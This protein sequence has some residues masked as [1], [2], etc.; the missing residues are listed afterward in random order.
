MYKKAILIIAVG[1]AAGLFWFWAKPWV[2]SPGRF[3]QIG[4][5]LKPL[6]T[7]SALISLIGLAFLL[8]K[9]FY[10][11]ILVSVLAG[12]PFFFV[13]GLS[14]FYFGAFV[15]MVLLFMYAMRN[16]QAEAGERMK[17]NIR[18]IM[19]GGL[20]RIVTAIL[21]MIS[22][23]FFFSPTVQSSAKKKQLPPTFQQVIE[24]TVNTFL[25]G[26]I[27]NLPPQERQQAENQVITQVMTQFTEFLGPYFQYLPPILAFGLFLILQGLSFIFVWLAVAMA[28][29][30]FWVFK[31]AG[32][33]R[34]AVVQKEAEKLEF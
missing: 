30:I 2:E 33:V 24:R 8:F 29:L 21:I 34:L 18:V 11:K 23:A 28:M 32:M 22:F 4:I 17:I 20:P 25:G 27:K 15:L 7:L 1:I 14:P 6:I 10:L 31:R 16:I 13:F 3:L 12:L 19:Q 26:E 5:W 9:N